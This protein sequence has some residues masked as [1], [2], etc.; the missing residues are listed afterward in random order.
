MPSVI[1]APGALRDL[2]RLR[3]FLRPKNPAASK[4]AAETIIQSIKMLELHPQIGRP[5]DDMEAAYRELV[6]DFGQYGYV[7]LYRFKDTKVTVVAIR[8]QLEAGYQI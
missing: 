5:R 6:I 8:H 7:A 2:G 1:F 4:R 3:E